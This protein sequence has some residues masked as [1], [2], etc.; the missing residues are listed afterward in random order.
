MQMVVAGEVGEARQWGRDCYVFGWA[1]FWGSEVRT[2]PPKNVERDIYEYVDRKNKDTFFTT[3]LLLSLK[4][5]KLTNYLQL[6]EKFFLTMTRIVR[7]V[8]FSPSHQT[9]VVAG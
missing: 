5:G 9:L 1:M 3:N 8:G 2:P 7:S 6:T 4:W